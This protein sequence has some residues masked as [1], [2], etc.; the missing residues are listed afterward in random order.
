MTVLMTVREYGTP[1]A[2]H[3]SFTANGD[4]IVVIKLDTQD[5]DHRC[6]L[7]AYHTDVQ[8]HHLHFHCQ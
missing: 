5:T 6:G 7:A 1:W 4:P 3:C 2:R 8:F